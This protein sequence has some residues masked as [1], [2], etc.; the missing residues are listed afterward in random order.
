[1]DNPIANEAIKLWQSAKNKRA[2]W[3]SRYQEIVD[4]CR[5]Q[6]TSFTAKTNGPDN[7]NTVLYDS[8]AVDALEEFGAGL[9][10]YLTN[11]TDRW[12]SLRPVNPLL[13]AQRDLK[14][15]CDDVANII[16]HNYQ[17]S[18]S[19]HVASL[20]EIFLDLGSFG[21]GVMHQYW[22]NGLK[23]KTLSLAD[24]WLE[25]NNEGLVD[26]V[27]R[28]ITWNACQIEQELGSLPPKIVE[29]SKK[30]A[31]KTFT[32]IHLVL[33]KSKQAFLQSIKI[34]LD[35]VSL[36][37]CVDTKETWPAKGFKFFPFHAPRWLKLSTEVYGRSPA[38][39]ALPDIKMLNRLEFQLLKAVSKATD[40]P[41][42]V[43]SD[44]FLLPLKTHPGAVN[45]KEPGSDNIERLEITNMQWP[46]Q[47]AEQKRESIRK[48][49]YNDFLRME[50]ADVEMTAYEVQD[51]REEKLRLLAPQLGRQESELLGPMI[52]LSY[53]LLARYRQIPPPPRSIPGGLK[54]EYT[55]PAARA[56]TGMRAFSM[57]RY[58]QRLIPSA[59][60]NPG[61]LDIVDWDAYAREMAE[62]MGTNERIL[63][64]PDAIAEIRNQQAIQ[65][66]M[67]QAAAVAEPASKAVKN[68]ND[69]G[70]SPANLING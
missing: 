60:L 62:A 20:S 53:L 47:K 49:F 58:I 12:F 10:A 65:A 29:A 15:W 1:M 45:Y 21:T 14:I 37:V 63:R 25:E 3:D 35:F 24:C 36:W 22:D 13:A 64:T 68:L 46:E 16:Y 51:R 5:P 9:H 7:T 66:Q 31:D 19:R 40:P 32:I 26:T 27:I 23:F 42:V 57:D 6:A 17:S 50:K 43:P 38:F 61:I 18:A 59:Q 34:P 48:M 4:Y 8:T 39:K 69:A 52:T 33:P 56:Q 41:L 55:S 28:Q 70:I 54:L 2:H 44:S 11:P 30:Q 67:A